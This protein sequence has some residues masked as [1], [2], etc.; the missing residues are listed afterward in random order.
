MLF[1]F[2]V[3]SQS[4]PQYHELANER[5]C[6]RELPRTNPVCQYSLKHREHSSTENAHHEYARCTRCVFAESVNGKRE[7]TAPHYG[8]E[9]SYGG[10]EPKVLGKHCGYHEHYCSERNGEEHR[11]GLDVLH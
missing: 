2:S 11:T 1:L 8:M 4:V 3:S 9:E 5:H 7:Y 6:P 10:K